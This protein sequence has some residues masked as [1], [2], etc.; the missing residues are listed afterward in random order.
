[1][2]AE[3]KKA[4]KEADAAM[5]AEAEAERQAEA[6]AEAER[7]AD[8][9]GGAPDGTQTEP[10]GMAEDV[11]GLNGLT[12][13][14][15]RERAMALDAQAV[16]AMIIAQE[17][18]K[19]QGALIA[20]VKTLFGQVKYPFLKGEKLIVTVFP[21][22]GDYSVQVSKAAERKTGN[23]TGAW[24]ITNPDTG[25]EVVS[26]TAAQYCADRKMN[27]GAQGAPAYLRG[28]GY[29]VVKVE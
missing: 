6:I 23:K 9:E 4:K 13:D 28:K 24:R 5:K 21:L 2:T 19:R 18:E 22:N 27:P 7:Q 1:M 12:D 3:E 10:K 15:L 17:Q 8:A 14:A 16:K 20:G 25:E 29:M 26:A 11:L